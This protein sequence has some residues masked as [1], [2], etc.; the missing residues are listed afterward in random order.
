[1][2]L[3]YS[4]KRRPADAAVAFKNALKHNPKLVAAQKRLDALP[5]DVVK[6]VKEDSAVTAS[7]IAV[8]PVAIPASEKRTPP[9]SQPT[10]LAGTT[11]PSKAVD[12]SPKP[13]TTKP[14]Q[15]NAIEIKPNKAATKPSQ[16]SAHEI[17]PKT[18]ATKPSQASAVESK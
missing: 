7:P 17:K 6:A 11:Q 18:V 15:A 1:M 14:S 13:V 16:A 10:A 9:S 5:P 2:G 4:S 12:V 8:A 3:M